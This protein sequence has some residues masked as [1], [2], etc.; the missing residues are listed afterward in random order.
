MVD[1]DDDDNAFA[2]VVAM[3]NIPM[4]RIIIMIFLPLTEWLV[5]CSSQTSLLLPILQP[6]DY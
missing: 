6:S 4:T 1:E 2:T 3:S 5:Y